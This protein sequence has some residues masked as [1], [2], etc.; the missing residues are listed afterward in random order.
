[1][2]GSVYELCIYTQLLHSLC[3]TVSSS[4]TSF[5]TDIP[6]QLSRIST[7]PKSHKPYIPQHFTHSNSPQ[8]IPFHL[9]KHSITQSFTI[10]GAQLGQRL[11]SCR[12]RN[13]PC[14]SIQSSTATWNDLLGLYTR[15]S[16]S[17]E[18]VLTNQQSDESPQLTQS[19]KADTARD[20][21]SRHVRAMGIHKTRLSVVY[22]ESI[23]L[24]H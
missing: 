4:C 17:Q 22:H 3:K 7:Q 15:M 2:Q 1:M 19:C 14:R 6:P 13:P 9:N 11:K 23:G 8:S 20:V 5:Y 21:A 12:R 18:I 24:L 10:Q 16:A